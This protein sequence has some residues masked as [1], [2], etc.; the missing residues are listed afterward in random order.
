MG[1]GSATVDGGS[2]GVDQD[3]LSF[4]VADDPATIT[5]S[6]DEAGT[7]NDNDGDS[8]SFTDIERLELTS[9]ADSV[10][11]SLDSSGIGVVAGAGDDTIIG[12]SGSDTIDGGKGN[13]SLTGGGGDDVFSVSDG[14]DT[15]TD[16]NSGNSGALG[17]SDQTNND[18]IDLSGYYDSL[19]ELRADQADDGILNQSNAVDEEGNAADYSDNTQFGAGS[20]TMQGATAESYSYDNTGIV[21]FANGTRIL[22]PY[23][24]VPVET[25]M[26][27]QLVVTLDHGPQPLLW[28]GMCHVGAEE[29]CKNEKLRPVLIKEGVLENERD[30]LVSRQ[31]GIML[32][33]DHLVRAIHLA[34]ETR[35][36]RVA[37]GRREVTYVHLL[38]KRHE[39]VFSEG[40]PSESFYP[41]PNALKSMSPAA[42]ADLLQHIPCLDVPD[43]FECRETTEVIY[44]PTA[45]PF[46][47][48][49]E[50]SALQPKREFTPQAYSRQN[51]VG[52]AVLNLALTAPTFG[53]VLQEDQTRQKVVIAS[54]EA[55]GSFVPGTR[56][57]PRFSP[58][59]AYGPNR[60]FVVDAANGSSNSNPTDAAPR[61]HVGVRDL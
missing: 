36:V 20:V 32:G 39:I 29:L 31:H 47:K 59:S 52:K 44:G 22:T 34:R 58:V 35:G 46:A 25:L 55:N 54:R 2:G 37:H 3:T 8:G 33:P 57:Q 14:N 24:D 51:Y 1:Y 26:P 43:A 13:D 48:A 18:F 41:G 49:H 16:F 42:R 6:G 30:L 60:P 7:Y 61:V 56:S 19:D 5:F 15:I 21:C 11:A 28:I 12:G 9:G 27:G 23:G 38:F 4:A 17:D 40:I 45:R 10:D 50:F 53:K